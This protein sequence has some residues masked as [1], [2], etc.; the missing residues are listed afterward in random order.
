[1]YTISVAAHKGGVGKTTIAA[2]IVSTLASEGA[3]LAV[4]LDPQSGLSGAFGID[5]GKPT[6]YEV[7]RGRAAVSTASRTSGVQGVTLLPADL[8]LA[9]IQVELA[10]AGEWHRA[11]EAVL[12]PH[13]R[14]SYETGGR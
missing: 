3:V 13:I 1:M 14:N 6:I 10:T 8:D 9:G 5:G 7:L 2:N 11:L 12:R 4:D